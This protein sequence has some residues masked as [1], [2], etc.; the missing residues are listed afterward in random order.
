[1]K[2]FRST[3]DLRFVKDQS[4]NGKPLI[5][6]SGGFSK[7]KLVFHESNPSKVYALKKLFKKDSQEVEYI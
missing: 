7:V 2:L 6:G 5:I 3:K 4:N 1:M